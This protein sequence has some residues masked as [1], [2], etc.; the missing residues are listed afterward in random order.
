MYVP[1]EIPI[2]QGF[3]S[4]GAEGLIAQWRHSCAHVAISAVDAIRMVLSL[5]SSQTVRH[6]ER[7][8]A[9]SALGV[10]PGT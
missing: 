6:A 4:Y 2:T 1:P 8:R 7:T 5:S 9:A 3:G 10:F